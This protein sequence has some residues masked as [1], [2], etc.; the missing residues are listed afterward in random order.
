MGKSLFKSAFLVSLLFF[1]SM[2]NNVVAV[3]SDNTPRSHGITTALQNANR[4]MKFGDGGFFM[5]PD[6]LSFTYRADGSCNFSLLVYKNEGNNNVKVWGEHI[7]NGNI[8]ETCCF[9]ENNNSNLVMAIFEEG[10]GVKSD[11]KFVHKARF[12]LI[13]RENNQ[14]RDFFDLNLELPFNVMKNLKC[15]P[16]TIKIYKDDYDEKAKN[17]NLL[18]VYCGGTYD[19]YFEI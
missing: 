14:G 1:G 4:L 3:S 8:Y 7:K 15:K 5:I 19:P 11:D 16:I 6:S 17:N 9:D 18:A 13:R 2:K 12:R 10:H